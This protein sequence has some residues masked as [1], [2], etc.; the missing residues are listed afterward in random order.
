MFQSESAR[1]GVN[2]DCR[3][4][5][6]SASVPASFSRD[7]ATSLRCQALGESDQRPEGSNLAPTFRDRGQNSL[8]WK[9]SLYTG[10]N[11]PSGP[12]VADPAGN[13]TRRPPRRLE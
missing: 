3:E 13:A 6:L 4:F 1:P 9:E 8:I 12:P 11:S 5:R 7:S 10:V 2:A